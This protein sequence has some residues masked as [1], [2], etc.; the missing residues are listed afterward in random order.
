MLC[1]NLFELPFIVDQVLSQLMEMKEWSVVILGILSTVCFV[2]LS[3]KT[4]FS[5]KT[6]FLLIIAIMV[7]N[8]TQTQFHYYIN[9]KRHLSDANGMIKYNMVAAFATY[10]FMPF[11]IAQISQMMIDKNK[12][13][14]G[15]PGK[16]NNGKQ[17]EFLNRFSGHNVIIVQIESLDKWII[18]QTIDDRY[19]MPFL[20][21]LKNKSVCFKN[22]LAQ[23]SGGGSADAEL[24]AL[25]GLLPL[26]THLGLSTAD[27]SKLHSLPKILSQTGYTCAVMH[28][29]IGK[30][31]NR[32]T[33][34]KHLGFQKLYFQ[35]TYSGKAA[36]WH[37]KDASFF[38][39]SIAFIEMLK[40]PF[41]VYMI[42]MQSHGPFQNHE[43]R[44]GD[45]KLANLTQKK[46][47]YV[48][49]MYEVDSALDKFWNNLRL[50]GYLENTIFVLFSDHQSGVLKENNFRKERIPLLIYSQKME[51][52]LNSKVG[53]HIDIPP[54]IVDLLN[55]KGEFSY[56]GESLF[57]KGSGHA[58][59]NDLTLIKSE[60]NDLKEV[61]SPK[62]QIWID[63]SRFLLN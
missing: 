13:E 48:Q 40:Q 14:I 31:F 36:G 60:R 11:L 22:F 47:D 46:K 54:T 45:D 1:S 58:L 42:T 32:S 50:K 44:F 41:F 57:F 3:G 52:D 63:Y 10:G 33:T 16:I 21:Q 27:Y 18:D 9:S 8:F 15:Y 30:F 2:L 26:Q 53:S 39:Q 24:S 49:T 19:V 6:S 17:D 23:H 29:N 35:N 55:I 43:G 4:V 28:A 37:S 38:E 61:N 7:C 62:H 59:F 25:T 12:Q 5:R 20:H 56:I 51:P 34:F